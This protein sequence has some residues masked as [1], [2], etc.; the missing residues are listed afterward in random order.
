MQKE[1]D[2][3]RNNN[4]DN[5]EG[6][7]IANYEAYKKVFGTDLVNEAPVTEVALDATTQAQLDALPKSNQA[8][9]LEMSK[10]IRNHTYDELSF[11][12]KGNTVLYL[13]DNVV[14]GEKGKDYA[15]TPYGTMIKAINQYLATSYNFV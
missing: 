2:K 8:N 6:K 13:G 1:F 5:L 10:R 11:S 4:L 15:G 9:V 3:N 7:I 12:I 14:A